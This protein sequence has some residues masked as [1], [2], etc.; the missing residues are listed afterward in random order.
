MPEE[1][2]ALSKQTIFSSIDSV[3]HCAANPGHSKLAHVAKFSKHLTVS[4][5]NS[6]E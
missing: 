1:L 3:L 5:L 2:D 6:K 4:L